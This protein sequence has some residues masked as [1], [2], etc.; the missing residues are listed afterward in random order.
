M[1]S[2][3]LRRRSHRLSPL[4]LHHARYPLQRLDASARRALNERPTFKSSL[5]A[6]TSLALG[7]KLGRGAGVSSTSSTR[8]RG[9]A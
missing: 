1:L 4:L 3:R 8:K 9:I 6:G 5:E 2:L 7:R